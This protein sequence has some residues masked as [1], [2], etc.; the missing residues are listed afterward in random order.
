MIDLQKVKSYVKDLTIQR[1][2]VQIQLNMLDGALQLCNQ[3]IEQEE[4][5][6]SASSE[7]EPN[8]EE[9]QQSV[10]EENTAE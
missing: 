9:I 6:L 5:V 3:M 8:V 2:Q 4:A 1:E 10:S 7:S